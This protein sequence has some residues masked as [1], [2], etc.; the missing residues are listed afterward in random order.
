MS[1]MTPDEKMLQDYIQNK[2]SAE[3]TEAV[4]L[5]LADHPQAL[6]DMQLDLMFAQGLEEIQADN[7]TDDSQWLH[8]PGSSFL[9]RVGLI[10][11]MAVVFVL[12]G[13]TVHFLDKDT[14]Q[15]MSQPDI[16]MLSTNRGIEDDVSFNH[17]ENTVIQIP[18]GYLSD[19]RY[20]VE[21]LQKSQ[22]IYQIN[23]VTSQD[24]L[25]TVFV[26]KGLLAAGRYQLKV[27]NLSTQES[28]TFG[29]AVH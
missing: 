6:Q 18:A 13:L 1:K 9:Q 14:G 29:L 5:W 11:A 26:P 2:L 15:S 10:A 8:L 7:P 3:Q 25:L 19:D 20:T 27:M 23:D 24:D 4:D 17:N 21:L 12:G 16:I 28:E 22:T